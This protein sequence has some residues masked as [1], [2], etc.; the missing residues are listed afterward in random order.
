MYLNLVQ[1]AESLGVPER[2]V[3]DWIRHDGLPH[4]SEQGRL[5][6]DRAQVAQWAAERGLGAQVG[7]LSPAGT[8]AAG[9]VPAE[10]A[11]LIQLL[12][13]GGI[14]R[15]VTGATLPGLLDGLVARL[16]GATP[17]V[18]TMLSQ[19]L[20]APGGITWAPVG[21]GFALPHPSSRVA[22]GRDSGSVAFVLMD[23]PVSLPEPPPDG[24]P[25][26]RL[27]FFIAPSPRAHLELLGHLSRLITR[28]PLRALLEQAAPDDHLFAALAVNPPG[29][30]PTPR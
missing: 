11:R 20:R 10:A 1:L 2:R 18:R 17:A 30:G 5:L 25:V 14:W 23:E 22:L 27:V 8:A 24:A 13:T 21:G 4:T 15:G 19:R 3:E 9:S 7:F 29:T 16:P 12:R 28:G 26:V 6:F